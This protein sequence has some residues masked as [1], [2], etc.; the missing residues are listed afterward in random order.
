MERAPVNLADLASDLQTTLSSVLVNPQ[1]RL[2][3]QA[4]SAPPAIM[5]DTNRLRQV[6]S[7]LVVTA[8]EMSH[9]GTLTLRVEAHGPDQAQF[10]LRAP[11][12]R[13]D[14][15]GTH[16]VSLALSRRLVE[17]HGGRLRVEQ[18]KDST[19]F[20]FILPIG[21]LTA[22]S[23]ASNRGRRASETRDQPTFTSPKVQP[24][25]DRAAEPTRLRAI[26]AAGRKSAL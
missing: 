20:E 7:N 1:L 19:L 4:E 14:I 11:I 2:D 23:I 13:G 17:L 5:A 25:L 22:D 12:A 8:A 3:V 6:L 15:E 26:V 9:E 10:T 21:E 18:Y 24:E 16:G